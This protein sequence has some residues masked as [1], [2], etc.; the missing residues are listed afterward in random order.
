MDEIHNS[1]F[2]FLISLSSVICF[3]CASQASSVRTDEHCSSP[4]PL[5]DM[6]E[7]I[8]KD[9]YSLD[10][11]I[12]SLYILISSPAVCDPSRIFNSICWL[13]FLTEV[14]IKTHPSHYSLTIYLFL[15]VW[16]FLVQNSYVITEAWVYYVQFT[17]DVR[18]GDLEGVSGCPGWPW[19]DARLQ[20]WHFSQNTHT[21]GHWWCLSWSTCESTEP[22]TRFSD[23]L[24]TVVLLLLSSLL[25]GTS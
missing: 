5:G 15:I 22:Q 8:L 6:T 7:I 16:F 13:C 2:R 1:V 20:Q 14:E 21:S 19:A 9:S 25:L 10:L 4:C 17:L 24:K 3:L 11:K 12:H 23:V 18:S